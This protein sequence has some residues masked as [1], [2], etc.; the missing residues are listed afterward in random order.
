VNVV[1]EVLLLYDDA[2]RMTIVPRASISKK[3]L[4]NYA[5]KHP[6]L[7]SQFYTS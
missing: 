2:T 6:F 5:E 3:G 7:D 4:L 1:G